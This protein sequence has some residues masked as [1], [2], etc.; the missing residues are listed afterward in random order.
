MLHSPDRPAV[1]TAIA[2]PGHIDTEARIL[3]TLHRPRRGHPVP[4]FDWRSEI[5]DE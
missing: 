3:R 5:E 4:R 1:I 2:T